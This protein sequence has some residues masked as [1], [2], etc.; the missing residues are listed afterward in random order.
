MSGYAVWYAT[1]YAT[2]YATTYVKPH[3]DIE[4]HAT[5]ERFA[6]KLQ[7]KPLRLTEYKTDF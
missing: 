6:N 5:E 3:T 1:R 7:K 4:Q 2:K